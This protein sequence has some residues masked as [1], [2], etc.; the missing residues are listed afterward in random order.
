MAMVTFGLSTGTVAGVPVGM[1]ISNQL[2]WQWTMA[3]VVAVGLLSMVAL[4]V[5]LVLSRNGLSDGWSGKRKVPLTSKNEDCRGSCSCHRRRHFSDEEAYRV[6]FTRP[7]RGQCPRGVVPGRGRS[8]GRDRPQGRA[9][10]GDIDCACAVAASSGSA[11]S[12]QDPAGRGPH[13]RPGRGL[14]GGCRDVAGRADRVRAGGL[15]PD[16]LPPHRYPCRGWPEGPLRD[17]GRVGR[18][19]RTW[20]R[21]RPR[22]PQAR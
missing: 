4:A 18:S 11:R 22:T 7:H 12:G 17:T 5:N 19:T 21:T 9:G 20:P 13:G 2:N 6:L 16:S 8:A 3:L 14:P 10:P 1:L 15:R